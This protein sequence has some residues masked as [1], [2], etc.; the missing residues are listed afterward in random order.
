[1]VDVIY[2]GAIGSGETY[3]AQL[4]ETKRKAAL[5]KERKIHNLPKG[6]DCEKLP[7]DVRPTCASGLCCGAVT[8]TDGTLVMERCNSESLVKYLHTINGKQTSYNFECIALART[9]IV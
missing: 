8:K 5:P 3:A 9:L 4:E 7:F 2:Y 6:S 1:M